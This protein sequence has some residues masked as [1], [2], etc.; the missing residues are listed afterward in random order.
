MRILCLAIV[1]AICSVVSAKDANIRNYEMDAGDFTEL[2]VT[3]NINVEYTAGEDSAGYVK[4]DC[5]PAEASMVSV[6]RSKNGRLE[7][8]FVNETGNEVVTPIC[9]RVRSRFLTYVENSG[10]STLTVRSLTPCPAL[11]ARIEGN[12]NL[13]L[14]DIS[15]NDLSCH[16]VAGH[17]VLSVSGKTPKAYFSVTGSG[18]VQALNLEVGDVKCLSAMSAKF[19]VAPTK[20]LTVN[21]TGGTI[22]YVGT[23]SIKKSLAI[24]VKVKP[25]S[26]SK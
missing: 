7:V 3:G 13:D 5:T 8:Q 4:Y 24:G 19:Y 12:G 26:E 14:R 23:P 10:D 22:Y 9:V 17:G 11:K 21:G 18:S 16:I 15:V 25:L 2:K 1:A 20:L 6:S